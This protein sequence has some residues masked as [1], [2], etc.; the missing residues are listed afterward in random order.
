MWEG[1]GKLGRTTRTKEGTYIRGLCYR[2]GIASLSLV[3]TPFQILLLD[4]EGSQ[5]TRLNSCRIKEAAHQ[6]A[7]R[8]ISRCV[9]CSLPGATAQALRLPLGLPPCLSV[10]LRSPSHSSL[11]PPITLKMHCQFDCAMSCRCTCPGKTRPVMQHNS[12]RLVLILAL[13]KP[14]RRS[15]PRKGPEN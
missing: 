2:A 14:F 3:C 10:L 1:W 15:I 7:R 4:R 9:C 12:G 5:Q 11:H 6:L 8:V 13:V